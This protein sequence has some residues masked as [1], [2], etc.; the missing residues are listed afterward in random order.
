M[1]QYFIKEKVIQ[2]LLFN[3]LPFQLKISSASCP[4]VFK[5]NSISSLLCAHLLYLV[6]FATLWVTSFANFNTV[7]SNG[8]FVSNCSH[9][10]VSLSCCPFIHSAVQAP[11][12][13]VTMILLR[14]KPP[15]DPVKSS[16]DTHPKLYQSCPLY[17]YDKVTSV[18]TPSSFEWR[19]VKTYSPLTVTCI[20][21]SLTYC[22]HNNQGAPFKI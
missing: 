3:S 22:P 19:R 4:L 7:P 10:Q 6:Y 9:A 13:E 5:A 1:G 17:D 11:N 15:A 18:Q 2:Y 8:Y 20:Y 16:S 21:L 12:P 14:F